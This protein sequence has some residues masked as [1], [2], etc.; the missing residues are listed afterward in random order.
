MLSMFAIKSSQ[1]AGSYYGQDNYYTKQE[2]LDNSLWFGKGADAQQLDGKIKLADF[3]EKLEGVVDG[4]Q[5]GRIV[6][7]EK[8]EQVVLHRP[9]YDMTFSAPKSVSIMSEVYGDS[10]LREAHER[11]VQKTL[12]YV[13]SNLIQT[14]KMVDGE[15]QY[16]NTGS[17]TV[18]M[19]QHDTSRE[20]D[21]QTHTHA[22][23]M[24]MTQDQDGKW[25]SIESKKIFESQSVIGAMYTSELAKQVKDLGYEIEVTDNRG[26]FEIKGITRDQIEHFSQRRAQIEAA[27]NEQGLTVS[28][29][30]ASQREEATLNSRTRKTDVERSDLEVDWKERAQRIG[31]D[32][33]QI[34]LDAMR[35]RQGIKDVEM[36]DQFN[37]DHNPQHEIKAEQNQARQSLKFAL[38]HLTEREAVIDQQSI[39]TTAIAHGVGKT[40]ATEIFN[41][42]NKLKEEGEI[43]A[44][45]NNQ[46]TTRSMLALESSALEQMQEKKS[47]INF[48]LNQADSTRKIQLLENTQGFKY[49]SGQREAINTV[50]TSGDK[51]VAV[52]G[53]AGTGK[54]TMLKG[55]KTISEDEG[56]Q[57]RGVAPTGAASKVLTNETGIESQTLAMFIIQQERSK[58]TPQPDEDRQPSKKPE[59]WVV[60]EASFIGSRDMN[61]L[62]YLADQQ[63]A[64]VVLLGDKLQLQS[65][66]AGKP[67]ELLQS[68]GVET[69]EMSQINRQKTDDLR[70]VVGT[71]VGQNQDHRDQPIDQ[72]QLSNT[73]KALKILDEKSKIVEDQDRSAQKLV[74]DYLNLSAND[75]HNTMIITPFNKDRIEINELIRTG[76]KEQGQ[77]GHEEEATVLRNK[78][79]TKAQSTDSRFFEEGD[80]IRFGRDYKALQ[81]GKGEYWTVQERVDDHL[82]IA[83]RHGETRLLNP[84][85]TKRI[86]VYEA[87]QRGLGTGDQI[88]FTRNTEA[89]KNGEMGVVTQIENRKAT[90]L[91]GSGEQAQTHIFD[92]DK[93]QHWDHAY[94]ITVYASQGATKERTMLYVNMPEKETDSQKQAQIKAIGQ[95]FG[96]RGFYVAA[97]RA[98]HDFKVYTNDK[99]GVSELVGIHQDKTSA[100]EEMKLN[101]LSRPVEPLPKRGFDRER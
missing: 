98:T 9:A 70:Q 97:T 38:A 76:L 55:L 44:L 13:E 73:Q 23:V 65:I 68:N 40:T 18:A 71:I 59:V 78:G 41:E 26:N 91:V 37:T 88:R 101:V 29:A 8:G 86:E 10:E 56:Y 89:V 61:R 34:K 24:N 5:L 6:K 92:L 17:M 53:L 51:Y 67:F 77:L 99:Q 16:Q 47:H 87:D 12:S 2:G 30:D 7:D 93:D 19:F 81:I 66:S 83:N 57:L 28:K 90:V 31:L 96:D 72:L 58:N 46:Y 22:L 4:Q 42:F 49:T 84:Q 79:L 33:E 50:L 63:G 52:Q 11:A 32:G 82:L 62:M 36:S 54:T 3:T 95:I 48:M 100:L 14:R 64:K 25:R 35:T 75:R 39:Y 20:L 43:V 1:A 85:D 80:V 69:A 15:I 45:N 60:D 27:L 74:S 21:P 94:S